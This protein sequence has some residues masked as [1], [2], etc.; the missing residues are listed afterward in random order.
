VVVVAKRNL[1]LHSGQE[2]VQTTDNSTL[3]A[4]LSKD[5]VGRR[6]SIRSNAGGLELVMS[7]MSI[8]SLIHVQMS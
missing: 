1:K 4:A 2:L 3:V 5:G 7:D 8:I 6:G